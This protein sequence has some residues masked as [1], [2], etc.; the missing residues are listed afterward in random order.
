MKLNDKRLDK[1]I[2]KLQK[3]SKLP[4]WDGKSNVHGEQ[5]EKEITMWL[6][7]KGEK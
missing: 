1:V 2:K 4:N 5:L 3:G 6:S 7:K